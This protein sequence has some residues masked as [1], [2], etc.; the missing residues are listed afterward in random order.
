MQ[1]PVALCICALALTALAGGAAAAGKA[2][3]RPSRPADARPAAEAAGPIATAPREKTA[4]GNASP[5]P[6]RGLLSVTEAEARAR[7]GPPDLA[8][9]EGAGSLWTYRLN[10]CALLVFFKAADGQPLRVS[11]AASGPRRRGEAPLPVDACLGE[12]L[13]RGAAYAELAP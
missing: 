3:R 11:G 2:A 1:R 8:R 5:I 4:A 13:E 10:H 7:L 12:A 9:T 6:L